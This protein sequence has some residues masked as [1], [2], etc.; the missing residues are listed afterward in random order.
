M[1][2]DISSQFYKKLGVYL[3]HITGNS[4]KFKVEEIKDDFI[5]LEIYYP[6]H[7]RKGIKKENFEDFFN[8]GGA[9][10]GS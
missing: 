8:G 2:P 1:T 9:G 3:S 4:C 10:G 6:V 7:H 5:I